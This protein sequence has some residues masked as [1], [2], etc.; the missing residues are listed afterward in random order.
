VTRLCSA[1][2]LL[3]DSTTGAMI[4]TT[5]NFFTGATFLSAS[6]SGL[7]R[8]GNPLGAGVLR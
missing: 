7:S 3:V 1:F 4:S 2:L 6:C 5:A 8:D